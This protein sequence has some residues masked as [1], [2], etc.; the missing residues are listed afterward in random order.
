MRTTLTVTPETPGSSC[1]SGGLR[2][3]TASGT[4]FVCNG[5]DGNTA[6]TVTPRDPGSNECQ[7]GGVSVSWNSGNSNI[8]NGIAGATPSITPVDPGSDCQN[9]GLALTT[10]AGTPYVC[11]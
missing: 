9:G 1:T 11:N 5:I 8:C 3:D 10:A 6:V 2:I 7:T 4:S